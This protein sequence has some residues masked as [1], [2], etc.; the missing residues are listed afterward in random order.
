MN[1]PSLVALAV[2]TLCATVSPQGLVQEGPEPNNSTSTATAMQCGSQG[3][4]DVVVG[5]DQDW[6]SF[7]V[8]SA[9]TL[10]ITTGPGLSGPGLPGALSDTVLELY[11]AAGTLLAENDD[12]G[13]TQSTSYRRRGTYSLLQVG[14][15]AGTY[16]VNVRGFG[17]AQTGNYTLDVQCTGQ[18]PYFAEGPEPNGDPNDPI[19]PG[20]PTPLP[21]LE[22]VVDGDISMAGDS[23]WYS[24]SIGAQTEVLIETGE[25][26]VAG[27][28]IGDSTLELFDSAGQSIA[29]DDDGGSGAYSQIGIS[30]APG[31][32]FIDVRGFGTRFGTYRLWL[33]QLVPPAASVSESPEPNDTVATATPL[34]CGVAGVGDI[35]SDDH[36]YWSF[37]L[38]QPTTVTAYTEPD[39]AGALGFLNDTE[40]TLR[41]AAT[42]AVIAYDDDNGRGLYSEI[43]AHLPPGNYVWDV[44]GYGTNDVGD[45]V[46]YFGCAGAV[47]FAESQPGGCVGSNGSV[48]TAQIRDLEA[49]VIGTTFVV[50]FVQCPA[51]S[52]MFAM[53][54][55]DIT[56]TSSGF[57]LPFDL[58]F[59]GAPGCAIEVDPLVAVP[60]TSGPFGASTAVLPIALDPALVG[61]TGYV[62]GFV[63]DPAAN[64][65]GATTSNR[66]VWSIG[67][68]L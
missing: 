55:F 34:P 8:S 2:A 47:A 36:D 12:F 35:S 53:I 21:Q 32:Y 58:T 17:S 42:N 16:Y 38:T 11:D 7:G 6:W 51:A 57:P 62:Q 48:P 1:Q 9:S 43:V 24:F 63:P 29:A 4:G 65:F 26:G 45:Y 46:L 56:Q 67:D 20:T 14:V 49:P 68:R 25:S 50:D 33:W 28:S 5:G 27:G 18:Q 52:T 66:A 22:S 39:P 3:E 59:L 60:L 40:L 44:E 10:L 19:A 41:D 23:D 61:I 30:L 15:P 31:T 54:G 37:T 64:N 13:G